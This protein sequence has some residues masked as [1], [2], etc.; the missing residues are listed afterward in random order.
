MKIALHE[1]ALSPR[2]VRRYDLS[3]YNDE[4]E[5]L[6]KFLRRIQIKSPFANLN[7][8]MFQLA[9][10]HIYLICLDEISSLSSDENL[11]ILSY[12]RSKTMFCEQMSE[13]ARLVCDSETAR[14]KFTSDV[15]DF[16]G[17]SSVFVPRLR[18][19]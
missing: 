1:L 12:F 17:S 2:I 19:R 4:F 15:S 10:Q 9:G 5:R 16:F 18:L 7:R 11:L 13:I 6:V 14:T 8:G 3:E